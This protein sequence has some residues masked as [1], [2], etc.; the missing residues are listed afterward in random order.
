METHPGS[1]QVKPQI[2]LCLSGGL[3]GQTRVLWDHQTLLLGSEYENMNMNAQ[4]SLPPNLDRG[5]LW[6]CWVF[7]H[8][9]SKYPSLSTVDILPY[10]LHV[11]AWHCIQGSHEQGKGSDHHTQRHPGLG[12]EPGLGVG[13]AVAIVGTHSSSSSEG[14]QI[15]DGVCSTTAHS[16][17]PSQT[18]LRPLLPHRGIPQHSKGSRGWGQTQMRDK[19]NSYPI[20]ASERNHGRLQMQHIRPLSS[21]VQAP[22]GLT[23]PHPRSGARVQVEQ[24]GKINT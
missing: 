11:T 22:H 10:S 5:L 21:A 6:G 20:G 8:C 16:H 2:G 9:F 17:I 3:L 1:K 14:V 19:E 7:L 18:P 23:P 12:E 15:S 4:A 24:E 13:V